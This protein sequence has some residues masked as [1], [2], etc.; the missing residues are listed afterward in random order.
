MNLDSSLA[1]DFES[2]KIDGNRIDWL[3]RYDAIA[4]WYDEVEP[5]V[6][7]SGSYE[8]LPDSPEGKFLPALPLNVVEHDMKKKIE[9]AFPGCHF[10]PAR[11]ANLAQPTEE[12]L[13]LG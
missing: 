2:N 5:F 9:T 8:N 12:H 13:A 1:L 7:I 11:V 10:I 3:V 6:A 4:P